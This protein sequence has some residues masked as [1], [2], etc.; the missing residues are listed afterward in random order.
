MLDCGIF[1]GKYW[2]HSFS[3]VILLGV[4]VDVSCAHLFRRGGNVVVARRGDPD[5]SR[6]IV[7]GL[8]PERLAIFKAIGRKSQEEVEK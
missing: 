3:R 6:E 4:Q 7:H 8:H 1:L 2:S 5:T